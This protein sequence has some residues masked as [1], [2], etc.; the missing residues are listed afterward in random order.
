[1]KIKKF[2]SSLLLAIA[3]G[4]CSISAK[5][6]EN[7]KYVYRLTQNGA[8]SC[9]ANTV[10]YEANVEPTEG[11]V[12][13]AISVLNRAIRQ[14]TSICS[15]VKQPSQYSF[16]KTGFNW[17]TRATHE[18]SVE[19]V[20]DILRKSMLGLQSS[21]GGITHFHAI[22]ISPSW[23]SSKQFKLFKREGNHMFYI[24]EESK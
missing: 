6:N 24:Q 2:Y 18:K 9:L 7:N 22:G 4:F 5:A 3:V 16:Y 15:I 21:Y 12:L 1:M 19:V 20:L 10:F 8:I 17:N 23:A 11:K 13:V 14:N